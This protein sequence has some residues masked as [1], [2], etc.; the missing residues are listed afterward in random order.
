MTG[1]HHALDPPGRQFWLYRAKN[2]VLELTSTCRGPD[3]LRDRFCD[4]FWALGTA[5]S[6]HRCDTRLPP[7]LLHLTNLHARAFDPG[8]RPALPG[9]HENGRSH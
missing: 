6:G 9:G 8:H 3:A 7:H 2:R 4:S 5:A 1:H